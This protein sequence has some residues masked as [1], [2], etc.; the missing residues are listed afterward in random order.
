MGV[1]DGGATET[2][3]HWTKHNSGNCYLASVFCKSV[4][5]HVIEPAHFR[6]VESTTAWF[7]RCQTYSLDSTRMRGSAARMRGVAKDA[8]DY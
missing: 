4:V 7:H 6:G 2:L 1:M 8:V 3:T 5:S